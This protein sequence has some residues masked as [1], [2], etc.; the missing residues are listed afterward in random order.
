MHDQTTK[1]VGDNG[2][3][4]AS[5][6]TRGSKGA[7]A[8]ELLDSSGNQVS[9]ISPDP[10][11]TKYKIMAYDSNEN[12]TSIAYYTSNGGTLLA[13]DTIT[14]DSNDNAITFTRT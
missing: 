11:G 1:V 10:A 14:Y 5:I 2:V 3:T 8:V 13:T 9:S 12:I 4:I 7:I 6:T